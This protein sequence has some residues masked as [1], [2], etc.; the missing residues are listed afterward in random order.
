MDARQ[1][2]T[3]VHPAANFTI[4]AAAGILFHKLRRFPVVFLGTLFEAGQCR[5]AFAEIV[6]TG[7]GKSNFQVSQVSA[8]AIQLS[9]YAPCGSPKILAGVCR[10]VKKCSF[11]CHCV[12]WLDHNK[13]NVSN[14]GH[15]GLLKKERKKEPCSW[16]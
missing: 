12:E 6:K 9:M 1:T 2:S 5:L 16:A 15:H 14:S 13:F 11:C 4:S 10:K 3:L 7:C 8:T